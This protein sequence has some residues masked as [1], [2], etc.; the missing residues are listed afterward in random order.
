MTQTEHDLAEHSPGGTNVI[1][2]RNRATQG[3]RVPMQRLMTPA[4]IERRTRRDRGAALVEFAFV[5]PILFLLVFGIIEFGWGFLQ[6]L[7]VR[8]GAR[9]G[10]RL[11]A[12][13]SFADKTT[14]TNR[15][16]AII[17][18][19][20][21][22]MDTGDGLVT[23]TVELD[24]SLVGDPSTG[25]VGDAVAVTIDRELEQLTGFLGFALDDVDLTSKVTTRLEQP[26]TYKDGS[27]TC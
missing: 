13:N 3:A 26:A 12:V 2:P 19:V 6:N 4:T 23:V 1:V 7:D 10:A 24:G 21:A 11:A 20:C 22:R 5:M 16:D 15:V 14:P 8:H 17:D 27:G 25:E 18:E 9:E